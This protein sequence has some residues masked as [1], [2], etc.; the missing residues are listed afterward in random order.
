[1]YARLRGGGGFK[2]GDNARGG[3][4]TSGDLKGRSSGAQSRFGCVSIILRCGWIAGS[5]VGPVGGSMEYG[6]IR[7]ESAT[8]R[9]LSRLLAALA[10]DS[11]ETT[12][13]E[14][15]RAN[16]GE[17]GLVAPEPETE[18]RLLRER[19]AF[20]GR[21]DDGRERRLGADDSSLEEP[22][23]RVLL[24]SSGRLVGEGSIP[25]I[26]IDIMTSK[27]PRGSGT[28][29]ELVRM[30]RPARTDLEEG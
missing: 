7:G 30:P 21:G 19:T 23:C 13:G 2:L 25:C 9:M 12:S 28:P 24:A 29:E 27:S 17:R 4:G 16:E 10:K 1:M 22:F 20:D 3:C 15:A 26:R 11:P 18:K 8:E 14:A 6:F 5:N